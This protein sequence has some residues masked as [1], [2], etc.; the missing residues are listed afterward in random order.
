MI[1]VFQDFPAQVVIQ[2]MVEC[3]QECQVGEEC[4]LTWQAVLILQLLGQHPT[5][6]KFR[7]KNRNP[8]R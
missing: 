4:H 6:L 3:L 7:E 5:F 8:C 2:V 1:T